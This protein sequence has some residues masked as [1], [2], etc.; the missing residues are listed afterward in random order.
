MENENPMNIEPMNTVAP[1][2]AQGPTRVKAKSGF[3]MIPKAGYASDFFGILISIALIIGGL[4]GKLVLRG[5]QSSTALV[6][7]GCVFLAIDFIGLKNK[8]SKITKQKE[9]LSK[10]HQEED[11]VLKNSKQL[12]DF[13][14][15]KIYY[16]KSQNLLNF[17]PAVNG[18]SMN[19]NTKSYCYE[20]TTTRRRSILNFESLDLLVVFDVNDNSEIVFTLEN[21]KT[22]YSLVVPSNVTF[23]ADNIQIGQ[24][25]Q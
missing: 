10:M 2:T 22:E 8:S 5:T 11:A 17:L 1:V 14:P 24:T 12:D 7:A 3:I 13:V 23:V 16:D 18:V 21:N 15:V 9:R 25:Y 20:G 6:I 4:S 19:R